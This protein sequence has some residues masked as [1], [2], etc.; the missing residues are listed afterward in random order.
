MTVEKDR[1][2][3]SQ[4]QGFLVHHPNEGLLRTGHGF[5]QTQRAF[6][7]GGQESA[8]QKFPHGNLFSGFQRNHTIGG[9]RQHL[10]RVGDNHLLF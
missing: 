5:G 2:G 10:G 7:A 8:Q 4:V 6:V 3:K 1:L 9:S